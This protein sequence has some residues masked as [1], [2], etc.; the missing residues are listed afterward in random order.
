MLDLYSLSAVVRPA[1]YATS[2]VC[3]AWFLTRPLFFALGLEGQ[4]RR[5]EWNILPQWFHLCCCIPR[6]RIEFY[7]PDRGNMRTSPTLTVSSCPLEGRVWEP[8]ICCQLRRPHSYE[9]TRIV[10]IGSY[11]VAHRIPTVPASQ[12]CTV[13]ASA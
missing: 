9:G 7:G 8:T 12:L 4:R 2:R 6:A 10:G 13:D 3:F 5:C 1:T 11:N